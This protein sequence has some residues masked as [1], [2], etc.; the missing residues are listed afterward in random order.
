MLQIVTAAQRLAAPSKINIVLF[1]ESGAGKTTQARTLDPETTLFIDL[2]AGTLAIQGWAGDILDI[3]KQATALGAHPW[4]I[5]RV[6]A[7]YIGGPNPA[8][9]FGPYSKA[10]YDQ[11]VA[12]FGDPAQLA[13]Y[14]TIF[15]DSLTVA[16]RMAFSWSQKQPEAIS[17]KSGKPDNRSAYGLLGQEL[18][19]WFTHLQHCDRSIITVGI[20]DKEVDDLKRVSFKP[21]IE[22][23]KAG[24]E[25][26]G[27]FDQVLTLANFPMEGGGSYR[28]FVCQNGNPWGFPAKDRSGCLEMQEPPDLGALMRKIR[29]GQ[30]LDAKL[31]TTLPAPPVAA[32]A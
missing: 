10:A 17:E 11:V 12:A 5:A 28:A 22:G 3:R 20:L 4:E 14:T 15:V 26:P 6:I 30:R 21:Q 24:R 19:K 25:L 29:A 2:E 23:A 16:S 27:I 32:A 13:K 8:E 18:I 9:N 7:C 31:T 1:G